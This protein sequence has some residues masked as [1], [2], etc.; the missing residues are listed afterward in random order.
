MLNASEVTNDSPSQVADPIAGERDGDIH[1]FAEAFNQSTDGRIIHEKSP[2]GYNFNS[3]EVVPDESYHLSMP[4]WFDW[5]DTTYL[6]P[7]SAGSEGNKNLLIYEF[8]SFPDSLTLVE[9]KSLSKDIGEHVV[10]PWKETWYLLS[11]PSMTLYYS[12]TYPSL[13]GGDWTEHPDSPLLANHPVASPPVLKDESILVPVELDIEPVSV[14]HAVFDDLSTTSHSLSTTRPILPDID[15]S[16]LVRTG[17]HAV[18]TVTVD[19]ETIAYTDGR[20]ASGNYQIFSDTPAAQIDHSIELGATG[21]TTI[22]TQGTGGW[23]TVAMGQVN[24][25]FGNFK[26][27]ATDFDKFNAETPLLPMTVSVY[28]AVELTS[29]TGSPFTAK[30]RVRD[31]NN[32]ETYH[33]SGPIHVNQDTDVSLHLPE[34]TVDLS[35]PDQFREMR[36]QVWQDSGGDATVV[37]DPDG[38]YF[39]ADQVSP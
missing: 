26:E 12:D 22:S 21:T 19:S 4:Q 39:G 18:S 5:D 33:E 8:D 29:F 17:S 25:R 32:S 6:V 16:G 13:T 38:T 15:Q 28:G 9:N 20:D 1:L 34:K 27:F 30:L 10:F 23:Q 2:D 14:V 37:G 36:L 35:D 31:M 11:E 7:S 3:A 24:S